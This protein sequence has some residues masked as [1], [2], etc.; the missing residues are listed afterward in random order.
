MNDFILIWTYIYSY[1]KDVNQHEIKTHQ[2][3]HDKRP[4]KKSSQLLSHPLEYQC[5]PDSYKSYFYFYGS[6]NNRASFL[7][8]SSERIIMFNHTKPLCYQIGYRPKSKEFLKMIKDDDGGDGDEEGL[9]GGLNKR[10]GIHTVYP[11]G[12]S[13]RKDRQTIVTHNLDRF[14]LGKRDSSQFKQM[15]HGKNIKNGVKHEHGYI[16][17]ENEELYQMMKKKLCEMISKKPKNDL[18][19]SMKKKIKNTN[20]IFTKNKENFENFWNKFLCNEEITNDE[21][22]SLSHYNRIIFESFLIRKKYINSNNNFQWSV[23]NINSLSQKSTTKRQENNFKFIL[24]NL[25]KIAKKDYNQ[26]HFSFWDQNLKDKYKSI[27]YAQ[28]KEIG[29]LFKNFNPDISCKHEDLV[30]YLLPSQKDLNKNFLID[31]MD[32]MKYNESFKGWVK[33][34]LRDLNAR[35]ECMLS[36]THKQNIYEKIKRKIKKYALFLESNISEQENT[37]NYSE[38]DVK[39]NTI[40]QI[41]NNIL[42]NQKTKFP[43]SLIDFK[44]AKQNFLEYFDKNN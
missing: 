10:I 5:E 37:S 3:I 11:N 30:K 34:Y 8:S 17:C 32:K 44:K 6:N 25:Y 19:I 26:F 4:P 23:N 15:S 1:H 33:K 16:K 9:N 7:S 2:T 41:I 14:I 42:H 31:F 39:N 29:F 35:H 36:I 20:N 28:K 40:N 18:K 12:I 21:I 24:V 43:K 13:F 38:K 22:K 27:N